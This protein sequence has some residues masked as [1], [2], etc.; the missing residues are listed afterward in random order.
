MRKA[1]QTGSAW[2]LAALLLAPHP[3]PAAPLQPEGA[4]AVLLAD[5]AYD[6]ALVKRIREAKRR[7]ICAFY[8]FK[9]GERRD[10]LPAALAAELIQAGKRGVEVTVILEGGKPV[11]REN[12][13]AAR[14]LSRGGVRVV[15]PGGR[16]VTHVKAVVIDGRYVMI[17]SHN[18]SHAALSR[19]RELSLLVD[20][21]EL[22]AQTAKYL[23]G[24][25]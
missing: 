15:I 18:L 20:S 13:A 4:K 21:P 7:I 24:I 22:A 14:A 3:V 8:L 10:N 5:A 16:R 11:A 2:A 6:G 9:V 19:N 23:E 25:R 17:G 1:L 12:R